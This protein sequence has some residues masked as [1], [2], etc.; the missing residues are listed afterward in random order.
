VT[1]DPGAGRSA[2]ASYVADVPEGAVVETGHE[3]SLRHLMR[4]AA[5]LESMVLGEDRVLGQVRDAYEHARGTGGIGPVLEEALTKAIHVGERVRTETAINEGV[6]SMGSAA[7]QFLDETV[8]LSGATALVVGAGDI[9]TAVAKAIDARGV[10]ALVVANRTVPSAEHLADALDADA[11]G[12]GLDEVGTAVDRADVV[13]AATG[14]ADPVIDRATVA[15]AGE[16]RIVDMAQ[17]RDVTRAV[18]AVEGV[19]LYDLDDL[20]DVTAATRRRRREA[21]EE[22]EAM[23]D[24][25]FDRLLDQFKRKR[26]DEVIAAMHESAERVKR[27]ELRTALSRMEANGGVTDEQREV[28]ESLADALVGQLLAAPTKSLRDAAAED[29]WTTIA[30]ALKL[31]DPEFGSD[32]PS[33]V[34]AGDAPAGVAGAGSSAE[35][36]G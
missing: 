3:E 32:P 10:D 7:A 1:D 19:S 24:E 34:D 31:F 27:R 26:A 17:P 8:G 22:V 33:F 18:G 23:I 30:T 21:A 5:G 25:E 14:A 4:V 13:V 9:G 35:D 2:L 15:D 36:D 12:V 16:T 11:E 20:E 29:D 6:V 28:V